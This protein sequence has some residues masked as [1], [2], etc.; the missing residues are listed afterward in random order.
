MNPTKRT[1]LV[2]LTVSF[3]FVGSTASRAANT[4]A[5]FYK[6]PPIFSTA[7]VDTKSLQTIARFGPVG[8]GIDLIQ[9][10]FRMKIHNIEEGSP[11][12]ATGQ[13]KAGQIIE[14]INGQ[15]LKDIDPRIQLGRIITDAEASDGVIKF[16]V[17]DT[18]DSKATEVVVRIPVIGAYADTWPLRCAKSERIVRNFADYLAKPGADKGFSGLGTLFLLSTGEAGDLALAKKWIYEAAKGTPSYSW[19]L[20]Y[21]GIPLCEYYLRTGDKVVLPAIQRWVNSAVTREYLGAWSQKGG[22]GAVTYGGGGGHLNAGG[23]AV[24]TFLMLARECGAKVPDHTLHRVLRHFYRYVGKGNNPYGDGRPEGSFV[25]NGKNGNLAFAMAAAASL[26]PDGEKSIY[27]RARD[28]AAMSSFYTSTY[29][30]HGHTGGGIGEIWRSAAMGLLREKKPTHY[31]EFM[32]ARKWHYELSRRYDGSFCILGGARYDNTNWGAGY[33]LGYTIPRKTLRITGAAPTK[34]SVK[35]KLPDRPWG[36]KAD[37]AF[38]SIEAAA[39]KTGACQDLSAETFAAGSGK[40]VVEKLTPTG[41]PDAVIRRYAHHPDPIIRLLAT[42]KTVGITGKYMGVV[43]ANDKPRP[44]LLVEFL[45]SKDA[46]VRRAAL[47]ACRADKS[48]KALTEEVFGVVIGMLKDPAE[49][50]WVKDAALNVVGQAPADWVAP[51]ADLL[52]GYLKHEEWWLQNAALTALAPVVADERCYRKVLPAMGELL[53]TCQRFNVT[54]PLRW[55]PLRDNLREAGPAVRKLAHETIEHA[56]TEYA[57][58]KKWPGGQDITRTLDSNLE[59]LATA[60][61]NVPGGYDVLYKMAKRRFP[62]KSLPYA[63]VFLKANPKDFGPELKKAIRAIIAERLIPEFIGQANH[64]VSNRA[65]LLSEAASAEPFKAGYYIGEPRMEGLVRLYQRMGVHDY[66]W[67]DF[68][69]VWNQMQ[70]DYHSYDPLETKPWEPGWRYR[71]VSPPKG[72]AN[73]Y[74]VDFD[75]R[76]AG[77]KRG[78]QPFG[79]EDGELRTVKKLWYDQEIGRPVH[80]RRPCRHSFC[81]CA[82]P[83]RTFWDKEVL[84]MRGRFKFPPFREGYRYRLVVGGLSHVNGGDG[85]RIYINGKL[86]MERKTGVGKRAGD[87]PICYYLDKA[88]WPNFQGGE[89]TLAATSFLRIHLRSKVKGNHFSVWLQEMKVPPLGEK[90]ILN[91][92]T[93]KPMLSSAWQARQDPDYADSDPDAGRFVWDGRFVPNKALLGSWTTVDQVPTI[94]E[95]APDKRTNPRR[96]PLKEMT[97]KAGGKTNQRLWI[98]SGD[99]LMDLRSNQAHKVTAKTIGGVDYMF[100]E[101][102]GFSL[103]H[104]KGW[105]TPLYVMKKSTN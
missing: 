77:W 10:A 74:A 29:M 54:S 76:K 98:W 69:P 80:L 64:A 24:V 11:A 95:F 56:Y 52:M 28:S 92:A 30:L 86:L 48:G 37:D 78:P 6:E 63:D 59:F 25:D 45:T 2:L 99:T 32:D 14:S 49:S 61:A 104:P 35:F 105:K 70:W 42:L 82:E 19:H 43:G 22:V 9:P 57:G 100:V 16:V 46:R 17:K 103:R 71:K 79:Q 85:F 38:Y 102:G 90:V 15:T 101:V 1:S 3:C 8:M 5:G 89:T 12:A 93:V 21:G 53:R 27:A 7:P 91:S 39:D 31:R 94:D 62:T 23:T 50:W 66:D 26:T 20:G 55:G 44:A 67:R 72:M 60:L 75:A 41:L 68:G 36:T 87:R 88:W 96:G 51:H 33:A 81:R 84:L 18:P 40:S 65:Q 97:F 58:V 34:F 13:L 83:M 73:W 4:K 47:D